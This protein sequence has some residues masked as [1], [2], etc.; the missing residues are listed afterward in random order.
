MVER[1]TIDSFRAP[2]RPQSRTQIRKC[3]RRTVRRIHWRTGTA[4]QRLRGTFAETPTVLARKTSHVGETPLHRNLG[5]ARLRCNTAKRFADL[6]EASIAQVP[7]R[8]EPAAIAEM[9]KKGPSRN[10]GCLHD[11]GKPDGRVEMSLHI[12]DRALDVAGSDRLVTPPQ[13]WV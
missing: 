8:R 1:R 4:G 12:V 7:H 2:C 5:D 13:C 6:V 10:A 9:L 11:I 3:R